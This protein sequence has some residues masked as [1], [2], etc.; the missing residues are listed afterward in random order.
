MGSWNRLIR[1]PLGAAL[2]LFALTPAGVPLSAGAADEMATIKGIDADCGAIHE[3]TMALKPVHLVLAGGTWKV[4]SDADY[5]VAERTH[6][7]I[8]LVDAWKQGNNYAWIH[9]HTYDQN[10]KQRATEL[11]FRQADG[12]LERARQA[13]TIPDLDAASA[14][15]AYYASNGDVI[16]KVGA[17]EINDP[18]IAKKVADLPYYKSL[19]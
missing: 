15:V 14:K 18:M 4:A 3:A 9:A 5:A 1:A 10:G 6:A 7:S 8:T 2:V 16:A 11:C 17:F 19:P 13:T 12:S